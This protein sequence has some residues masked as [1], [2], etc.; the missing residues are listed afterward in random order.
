MHDSHFS[1]D[2][3]TFS[4]PESAPTTAAP[5]P[6]AM[7]VRGDVRDR[8]E[9]FD[10][11]IDLTQHDA[12]E[13][14]VERYESAAARFDEFHADITRCV[15]EQALDLGYGVVS[16]VHDD[17]TAFADIHRAIEWRNGWTA[18][19]AYLLGHE[20]ASVFVTIVERLPDGSRQV[21]HTTRFLRGSMAPRGSSGSRVLDGV[22]PLLDPTEVGTAFGLDLHRCWDLAGLITIR[23]RGPS[24]VP[25]AAF[26]YRA[27]AELVRANGASHIF[28]VANPLTIRSISALGIA[29][30]HPLGRKTSPYELDGID[31]HR[32][33]F[34]GAV[35]MN[36]TIAACTR[37]SHP[38]GSVAAGVRDQP[39]VYVRATDGIRMP[40]AF[41]AFES[42]IDLAL[43]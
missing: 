9:P 39:V 19:P 24:G 30:H 40:S 4:G 26:S 29:F 11:V 13:R 41:P 33:S 35:S 28:C 42:E 21:A 34:V 7:T 15:P 31:Y 32:G 20:H 37:A 43:V 10:I 5:L 3:T 6:C 25:Y 2:T 16:V 17:R 12:I 36:E 1:L 8:D 38:V 22:A 14:S 18:E 27:N 23:R